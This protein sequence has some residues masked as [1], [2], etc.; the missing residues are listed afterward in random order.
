M[1]VDAIWALSGLVILSM[2]ALLS[3]L[4]FRDARR[5]GFKEGGAL[6]IAVITF[7]SIPVG[8]LVYL[9]ASALGA[10]DREPEGSSKGT[11]A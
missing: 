9:V 6:L 7:M 1:G 2:A 5:R 8:P 10:L 3:V 11:D 4:I